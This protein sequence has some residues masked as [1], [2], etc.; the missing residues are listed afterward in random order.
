MA[1]SR[2]YSAVVDSSWID[3]LDHVNFLEYQRV[4]DQATDRFWLSVGGAPLASASSRLALVIIETHVHY[5]RELR[6]GDPVCVETQLVGY[7]SRR[8]HL[9]HSLLRR[10][11]LVSIVQILGLAFDTGRRRASH[12]TDS[13]LEALAARKRGVEAERLERVIDWGVSESSSAA[14]RPSP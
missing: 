6:R 10:E 3:V 1:D 2:L 13:M 7:D 9:Y 5:L 8:M 14:N 4:A 11:E 12:W